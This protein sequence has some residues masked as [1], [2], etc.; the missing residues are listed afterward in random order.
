[1]V[2]FSKFMIRKFFTSERE[3]FHLQPLPPNMTILEYYLSLTNNDT[4]NLFIETEFSLYNNINFVIFESFMEN[5]N[6]NIY[7]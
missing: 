6:N 4:I 7:L 1:M 2:G 3:F 5:Y